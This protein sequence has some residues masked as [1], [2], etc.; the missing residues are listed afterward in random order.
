M[1]LAPVNES[2]R[3]YSL[4][5][6]RERGSGKEPASHQKQAI[7]K[8]NEWY[9]ATPSEP[10]GGVLVL[11]TGAGKTFTSIHFLCSAAVEVLKDH[12]FGLVDNPDRSRILLNFRNVD[13][14][15]SAFLGKL[16]N[17]HRKLQRVKGKLVV[18]DLHKDVLELFASRNSTNC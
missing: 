3:T 12:L 1:Q 16:L 8:L 6:C 9:R 2:F 7:Q 14:M 11:P 18:C 5:A 10:R 15:S 4:S 17:L 13:F